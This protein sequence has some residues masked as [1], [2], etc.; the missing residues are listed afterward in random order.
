MKSTGA[1][2]RRA[3]MA[4]LVVVSTALVFAAGGYHAHGPVVSDDT[5]VG[6]EV[7][8]GSLS[9]PAC[10]LSHTPAQNLDPSGIRPPETVSA[11]VANGNIVVPDVAVVR[12]TSCRAPPAIV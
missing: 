12:S 9:C 11:T 6:V 10:A 5:T 7:G 2:K 3:W 1:S 8:D 4:A